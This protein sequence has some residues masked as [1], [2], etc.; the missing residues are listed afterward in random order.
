MFRIV[1][2]YN[3]YFLLLFIIA[4]TR[5]ESERKKDSSKKPKPNKMNRTNTQT[6]R[7][8]YANE[9]FGMFNFD[10]SLFYRNYYVETNC[11]QNR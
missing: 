3:V 9:Q 10:N 11:K 1:A 2:K 6:I 4:V 5:T 8:T 7:N